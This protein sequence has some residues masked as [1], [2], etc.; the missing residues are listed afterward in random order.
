MNEKT[1][2]Y[3]NLKNVKP[4]KEITPFNATI[5]SFGHSIKTIFSMI[6][7]VLMSHF[8]FSQT[9]ITFNSSGTFI[10]P[11]GVTSIKVECWGAGGA[12]GGATGNPAAGGGG[13]GGAYVRN[14]A[15]TVIPGQ[16]YTFTV[17]TGGVGAATAGQAGRDSWFGSITTILAKGGN[18]GSLASTNNATAA[19]ASAISTG[20]IG[21]TSPYSYFGGAGGTGANNGGSGGGGGSSAGTGSNGANATGVNG[22]TAV[23]GGGAGVNGS[24]TSA[25]G[26]NNT[27]L[28][29]GGAGARATSNTNRNGGSGGNGQIIIT[30]NCSTYSLLTTS[31]INVCAGS[32][33]TI[34]LTGNT[35]NLPIG[36]YT[37]S[38]N[39]TG[40]N[41][42][43]GSIAT[44]N[45][46]TAGAGSFNTNTIANA[47]STTITITNLQ[48]GTGTTICSSAISTN[49][50]ATFTVSVPNV[51]TIIYAGSP[52]CKSLTTG[53]VT[54]T[55]TTGGTYS[56]SPTGL[57][58]NSTTG[59]INPSIST[60][61]V[62]TVT[63]S[64]LANG[65]CSAQTATSS[66]TITAIPSA[67]IA[68]SGSPFCK[69]LTT[70]AV[71][72]TGT[73]GGTYSASPTGLTIN[74]TTGVI[75]PSTSTAG[76]YTVTYTI[77][78]ANG[79]SQFT[80]TS[81]VVITALPSATITYSGSPFCKSL[82]TGVV[83][84]TGTTGGTY[85]SSPAGLNIDLNT[86]AIVPS[87]STAGIYSVTYTVIV[88]GC[89]TFSTTANV[90]IAALPIANISG[91]SSGCGSVTLVAS[92]GIIYLWSG[93]SSTN[94]AT[95]NFTTTGTYSVTVTNSKGCVS[96]ASYSITVITAPDAVTATA[97]A[98]NVCSG[99]SISLTSSSVSSPVIIVSEKFNAASTWT[100][101]N[102]SAGGTT[103][104]AAWTLRPN[105][106]V[107][108]TTTFRSNDLSQFYLSNSASQGTG[109]TT[110]TTLQSPSFSTVGYNS[111]SLSFYH[112]Y[113]YN[114]GAESAKVEVSTNGTNWT[115]VQTYNSTQGTA[116]NFIL[117]TISLNNYVGNGN[118]YVRFKY[119][120]TND[121][122]WAL[123]NVTI[124]GTPTIT[125][126]WTSTPAGFTSSL[127]NPTGITPTQTTIYSVSVTNYNG[128]SVTDTAIVKVNPITATA[129]N[130]PYAED[131]ESWISYC[132][133][134]DKP[135][136]S[137]LNTPSTGNNSWR[138][139]DQGASAN[140]TST[141]GAYSP[142][143][144][145]GSS[146]ARFH[147]T[148]SSSN[149]DLYLNCNTGSSP[150]Q[151]SFDYIN[152]SGIDNLQVY[153]SIDNGQT[154]QLLGAALT[155]SATWTNFVFPFSSTNN[156][157]II[158]LKSTGD[159]GSTDIGVDNLL[160]IAECDGSP[161]A[162]TA[163]VT[164]TYCAG[165]SSS[166]LSFSLNGSSSALGIIYQWQIKA[167]GATTFTNITGASSLNYAG[168]PPVF[169]AQYRCEVTCTHS[170][171]SS[172]SSTVTV[173]PSNP[174][175]VAAIPFA[176]S[177]E[178]WPSACATNDRPGVNWTSNVVT[179]ENAWRRVDQGATAIWTA[180][181]S[182]AYT[183]TS[184][185]GTYSARFHTWW[186]PNG[187]SGS[188]DAYINCSTG[189][190]TKE[191]S[192]D[193][194]NNDGYDVV[195]VMIST[196]GGLT[197]TNIVPAL[198]I[199]SGWENKVIPFT[200][201]SATT[202]IRLKATSDWGYSDIGVD[203]FKVIT[204]AP[205]AGS[206]LPGNTTSSIASLCAM[207]N[208]PAVLMMQNDVILGQT[209]GLTYQWQSSLNNS[210]WT[211][212]S[213]ATSRKL[214]V[215]NLSVS[216]Y[217]K[218][219]VT[220][221]VSGASVASNP[222]LF[223]VLPAPNLQITGS[224]SV[225]CAAGSVSL[226]AS[227][228]SSY[229]WIPT[230]GLSNAAIANPTATVSSDINY[231]VTGTGANGCTAT[232]NFQIRLNPQL[233]VSAITSSNS[234]LCSN[235]NTQLSV[236]AN[237]GKYLVRPTTY[238]FLA[239]QGP[240]TSIF[241]LADDAVSAPITIPFNFNFYGTNQ[242][243]A[244][245]YTNGFI[246][247]GTSSSS[248]ASYGSALPSAAT[249]NNIIAGLWD[250]L[251]I[252]NDA[253]VSYFVNGTAPNRIFVVQWQNV[254]FYNAAAYT[255]NASFQIQLYENNSKVEVHIKESND[256]V[257]SAHTIGIENASGT[258]ANT[259]PTRNNTA[260]N[261]SSLFPEAYSFFYDT[262]S[263]NYSWSPATFLNSTSINNPTVTA[264]NAPINYTVTV[265]GPGGCSSTTRSFN[266]NVLQ[267]AKPKITPGDTTICAADIIYL[268][269]RDTGVYALG[270][271]P[272]T[273]VDWIGVMS[274]LSVLDSV[275]S[276]Q[277]STF[278]AK[279][280][281]PNGCN[282]TSNPITINTRDV[283]VNPRIKNVGCN[284]EKGKVTANIIS[285]PAPPYR[286]VWSINS[287]IIK[288]T[289]SNQLSDS[290]V[291]LNQGQYYL[292]IYD[293]YG[294]PLSCGT[295]NIICN[296]QQE[297][298]IDIDTVFTANITCNAAND[299]MLSVNASDGIPPYNYLWSNGSTYT[300]ISGL[301]AGV[302]FLTVT[303]QSGCVASTSYTILEPDPISVNPVVYDACQGSSDGIIKINPTGTNGL[304][305]VDWYDYQFNPI[306][307]GVDSIGALYPSDY[308]IVIVDANYCFQIATVSVSNI[309]ISIDPIV[310]TNVYS[311]SSLA[312]SGLGFTSIDSIKIN[313]YKVNNYTI[314]DDNNLSVLIDPSMSGGYIKIFSGNC[315]ATSLD[316][317]HVLFSVILYVDNDADGFG[318][319]LDSIVS[320]VSNVLG[321]VSDDSDCDDT[322]ANIN[323]NANEICNGLDDN[324]DSQ[325]DEGLISTTYYVDAD[326]DGYGSTTSL[327]VCFDPG[328]GY[329]LNNNDCDDSNNNINP[330][331]TEICNG[332]D[333]DCDNLIDENAFI[334]SIQPASAIIGTTITIKG[335]G[336]T[337]ITSVLFN[338]V[339]AI[340]FSVVDDTTITVVVP[341]GA[342]NGLITLSNNVCGPVT[343]NSIFTVLPS[344]AT[345]H[346]K[347]FIQGFYI[348][349]GQMTPVLYNNGLTTD[350]YAV[351]SLIIELHDENA[352]YAAIETQTVIL[353]I[354][355]NAIAQFSG[356]TIGNS[357]YV[358]V[359]HRNSIETWSNDPV[360]IQSNTLFDFAH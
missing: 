273:T 160:V 247:L 330:G 308:N 30:Y 168:V 227:G 95:N 176:E 42:T 107:Y 8:S 50:T 101:T 312:I 66:V 303:D 258:V 82:T 230:T 126:S 266:V 194:I 173:T 32:S 249:P 231:V 151:L 87:A 148:G 268:K 222:L 97:S 128:C 195:D 115:T 85:S 175:T 58:I 22:G 290:I 209:A 292:S 112:Y 138:R 163:I 277:A 84:Q 190:N 153:F 86:G 332:I 212:I 108:S 61:G 316:S 17:G 305:T 143:S 47:G 98:N 121:F 90:E 263:I 344:T 313:N 256:P 186:V 352:P 206:P 158:R 36:T 278:I 113:R 91:P 355:G 6:V 54:Q 139:N 329:V 238:N 144:S 317:I 356:A 180:P 170:G 281:L 357:Y 96:N 187:T 179:G 331:A 210:L 248:T 81:S 104:N 338:N 119:D 257:L 120:A 162:G 27:N 202:I 221:A 225:L 93:G 68:Y 359:K 326:G 124:I 137:W 188:I 25:D 88:N 285:P 178:T 31:A 319:K 253:S 318:N 334:T 166:L 46:T 224:A 3:L 350:A 353:D 302:Y 261:V 62:Y 63:Y 16:S 201:S 34:S 89:A 275:S 337:G 244:Y 216:T 67:T 35:V 323:P 129:V 304:Y 72:Q 183:P 99:S 7:F 73:T 24:T 232:N 203:N 284:G 70:G 123:D 76:T 145:K 114:S 45:V 283:A 111:L 235:T 184:T 69:S 2:R 245:V 246:Q 122:Y 189:A 149:L 346:L 328:I 200:S 150:K 217:Y 327:M 48:S 38:Y 243:T 270:Y 133:T 146:S 59:V 57:T 311:N 131:F 287:Q 14:N 297:S 79:C 102:T 13:A 250:D 127:P 271:P 92:G 322:N 100:T 289:I 181:T 252:L 74:S 343:S 339:A 116:T 336:F 44:M 159:N 310:S 294:A 351:D 141:T 52:F 1:Y 182:A 80:T 342:Q 18:G 56:V 77:A 156:N 265:T 103:A 340:S 333:D 167:T 43:T 324:C 9:A 165:N 198:T 15:I 274:G 39:L 37:V 23:T 19:G 53:V 299:G 264:I 199:T 152:T 157:T 142:V 291:N 255:G 20:N 94:A 236:S 51:A 325:I 161:Q 191:L 125:Y 204:L 280:V 215:S 12:G 154:F 349:S 315:S 282:S 228:A 218:C 341:V 11:A 295:L 354:Y 196:D 41:T 110:A 65:A 192:F 226:T 29:G 306:T 21:S 276:L 223:N 269:V 254:N 140:W 293:N 174:P 345:L 171:I 321:Y 49:R 237:T 259:Y 348:G 83:T 4:L 28:G 71:T 279:V 260:F 300:T 220:C 164:G 117:T 134:T 320:Y 106:Y 335:S 288:D 314:I 360:L 267:D 155:V 118:V 240:T 262:T 213:G 296:V 239:P 136:V 205:C 177:F 172:F 309:N 40:A 193:Y 233:I 109:G 242:N 5:M 78:A 64:M 185:L 207:N 298:S 10:P 75:N 147:T 197:F 301:A 272:N 26:A 130:L 33:S 208:T 55:G 169:G 60:A 135:G 307:S 347:L 105:S 214:T 241:V 132:S 286:Y 234:S 211:N 358:V 251:V 229:A 219:I